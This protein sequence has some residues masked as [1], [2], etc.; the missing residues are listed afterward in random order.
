MSTEI[1]FQTA[2][3]GGAGGQNVNKVETMV[4]GYWHIA[5]SALVTEQQKIVLQEKLSNR[6]NKEGTLI[7]KSQVHRSQ[8][9]NKQE[10]IEKINQL[11]SVALTPKKARI[12]SKPSKA[13]KERRIESKKKQSEHKQSRQKIRLSDF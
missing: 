9:A 2:R 6:I 3:S 12:A 1:Q 11:I 8:Q 5:S 13:S 4:M 10:V 7:V